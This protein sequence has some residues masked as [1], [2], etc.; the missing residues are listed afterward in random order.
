MYLGGIATVSG[1]SFNNC[2]NA[3]TI[4]L[5]LNKPL[6]S[7]FGISLSGINNYAG[8]PVTNSFNAGELI[9]DDSSLDTPV[10]EDPLGHYIYLG[11][12]KTSYNGTIS[13]GNKFNTNPNGYA[14][15]QYP[16]VTTLTLEE[17]L[18]VGT[19]TT[20]ETP[21]ILSVINADNAY[22]DELDEGGLPTLKAFNE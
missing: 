10:A 21:G 15:G 6:T 12:I 4:K 14:I 1:Q 13:Y 19:Y 9:I 7:K 3:G 22:N 5:K 20:E 17:V 16:S 8:G 18:A 11:E 2:V